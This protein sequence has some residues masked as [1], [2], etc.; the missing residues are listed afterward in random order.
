MTSNNKIT[1]KHTST[2]EA[3]KQALQVVLEERSDEQFGLY[4]PYN[5][6]NIAMGKYFRFNNVNLLAGLSGHAKS[7]MLNIWNDAFL[8]HREGINAGVN[9]V[10]VVLH[11]CF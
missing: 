11:F 5:A 1:L 2:D 10:P 8:Q 6:L 7:Y 4:S 9:F 3:I